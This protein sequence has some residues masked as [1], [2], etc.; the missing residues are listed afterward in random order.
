LNQPCRLN[1]EAGVELY[2]MDLLSA[3]VDPLRTELYERT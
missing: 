1:I 2:E 3:G